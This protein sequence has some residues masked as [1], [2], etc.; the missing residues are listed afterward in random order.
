MEI[1]HSDGRR[2][3]DSSEKTTIEEGGSW[4]HEKITLLPLNRD[5]ESIEIDGNEDGAFKIVAVL[6]TVI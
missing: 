1:Q 5:Y 4:H 6:K 2:V 3:I